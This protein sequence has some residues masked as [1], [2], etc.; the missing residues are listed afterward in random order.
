M[1]ILEVKAIRTT[2]IT[3][4]TISHTAY[5]FCYSKYNSVILES[6]SYF[7]VFHYSPPF[8]NKSSMYAHR[9]ILQP[10]NHSLILLPSIAEMNVS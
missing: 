7:V 8:G 1:C 2:K 4:Y 5:T 10:S 6:F 9:L 3:F